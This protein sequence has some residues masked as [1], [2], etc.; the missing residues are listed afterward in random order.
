MDMYTAFT[1]LAVLG[2]FRVDAKKVGADLLQLTRDVVILALKAACLVAC[3]AALVGYTSHDL[4]TLGAPAL[5][6]P[7]CR[8]QLFSGRDLGWCT[9]AQLEQIVLADTV[10]ADQTTPCE[11][12]E[13]KNKA[14]WEGKKECT[15]SVK[16]CKRRAQA[17]ARQDKWAD[18]VQARPATPPPPPR[19]R[20]AYLKRL[21][22][23]AAE[24]LKC[25]SKDSLDI[26]SRYQSYFDRSDGMVWAL[27]HVDTLSAA[28]LD[29]VEAL[30]EPGTRLD[31]DR[32]DDI[33]AKLDGPA[34]QK[35]RSNKKLG[36]HQRRSARAQRPPPPTPKWT[37]HNARGQI[38]PTG[39]QF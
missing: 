37:G 13:W 22:N 29:A 20:A 10:A 34:R 23:F 17:D 7:L 1:A 5:S 38:G 18:G 21:T 12:D 27:E 35:P 19:F 15:L 9:D 30:V 4:K 3:G 24:N 6:A 31:R 36:Q 14:G 32:T 26:C 25:G 16:E 39:F 33:I 8:A 11:R 28:T 2:I